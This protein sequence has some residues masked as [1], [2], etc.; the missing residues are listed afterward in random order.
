MMNISGCSD[1]R[2]L[3]TDLRTI[4]GTPGGCAAINFIIKTNY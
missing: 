2:Q 1:A 3:D 4:S